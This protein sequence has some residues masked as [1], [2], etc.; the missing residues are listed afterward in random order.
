[1]PNRTETIKVRVTPEKKA[2]FES[3]IEETGEFPSVSQ[4]LRASANSHI[5]EQDNATP[6]EINTDQVTNAVEIALSDVTER[7]ERIEHEI[8]RVDSAVQ[9]QE[10]AVDDLADDIA[11]QLPVMDSGDEFREHQDVL[12]DATHGDLDGLDLTK[13]MSTVGFW[14]DFVDADKNKTRRAISRA[15]QWYPDVQWTYDEDLGERRYYRTS[16]VQ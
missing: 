15:V 3:Y 12:R 14:S 9:P 11:V 10:E 6:T 1:M 8:V 2:K 5:D 4:L 16:E 7:L 13:E